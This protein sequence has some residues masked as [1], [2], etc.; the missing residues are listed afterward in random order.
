MLSTQDIRDQFVEFFIKNGHK[1]IE[2]S[3][4]VLQ[5]DPTLLFANAG[6][7]Q[8]KDNF[9]G[10]ANPKNKRAVTIQKCVRAGGKHNDLENVGFT[11]RHHTFFEMLGNFS[12]GD[13]FKNEAIS[14]AWKFLTQELNIPKDKL[15]VTVHDSDED[16]RKIWH[17]QEGVPLDRIFYM[18]DK[19]NFWEMGDSGP[20]GPCSEIF[21]DHGHAY[22][23]GSDT[24]S[25]L[26]NDEG[27]YVEIWNLVFMQYEKYKDAQGEIQ[28]RNLPKPCVDT[29]AGLERLTACLQNVYWNY[30]ID[31]FDSIKSEIEKI[32]NTKYSDAKSQTSIRVV[33]DHIRST[34]MLITDGVIPSNEGRGYVLRRMIRRAVRHLNE[35]GVTTVSFYK[36]VPA[37]FENLGKEYPQNKANADLATKMLKL[38][39]EKFRQTLKQGLDLLQKEIKSFNQGDKLTGEFAFKLYDTYGFPLDLTQVILEEKGYNLDTDGF[40]LAMKKQKEASKASSKF[41]IQEDNVKVFYEIKEKYGESQ[42]VGYTELT[43]SSTLL[44]CEKINDQY[45]L[46]FDKTPFYPEGGGQVGDC[47]EIRNINGDL[48][49]T[50]ES[51]QKPIDGLIAHYSSDVNLDLLKLNGS[52]NLIVDQAKRCLTMRNHSATHLLQ[53][54]LIK[55]LGNH[56]KQAGSKVSSDSLRFDFTHP[57]AMSKEE[58][59]NVEKLVN[60]MIAQ[61][62]IVTATQMTKDA[63]QKKG[64]MALFGEKYGEMVRVLEMGNFSLELCGGTH[65]ENTKEIGL[66]SITVETSL[67]SGVRRIEGLTSTH[68]FKYLSHRSSA[69]SLIER[70]F[71]AKS[72]LLFDKLTS[73]QQELKTKNKEIQK[74]H[75]QIQASQVKDLFENTDH[76]DNGVSLVKVDLKDGNPKDFRAISDKFID[77]NKEAILLLH[78]SSKEKISYLLRTDKKNKKLNCSNILKATQPIICGRGGGRPDMAQGSG[79]VSKANQFIAAIVSELKEI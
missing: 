38:E 26:L 43:N 20:C 6:M 76:F 5:N 48:I 12:F 4:I 18:G 10:K 13:Y 32:S 44:A 68:A 62:L 41:D 77:Q 31:S 1:K 25:C 22:S 39:E 63:A 11:A 78:S 60:D 67:S 9:T 14:L 45:A 29:G 72:D 27:R 37:V 49:A 74:L 54:A 64:A 53:S 70:M 3:S 75:D 50:I 16:A 42:F 46:I 24:S 28:R 30:D 21:Y 19:D 17:E 33:C 8:F 79:D 73:L 23:D 52:Y 57:E 65:V 66:F 40:N 59:A 15:Y 35:L 71:S 51:T 36:L 34:T 69:L 47:G 55:V 2:S 58:V 56:V 61:S 7:N